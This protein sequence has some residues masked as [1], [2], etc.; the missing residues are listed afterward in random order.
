MPVVVTGAGSALGHAVVTA[1][2]Q[3][4]VEVRVTVRAREER[5]WFAQRRVPAAV[6]DLSDPLRT[7]AV[8]EGAFTVVHLDSPAATWEWLLDAAEE[9]SVRRVLVVAPDPAVP[10]APA[11]LEVVR[12]RGDPDTADPQVVAAVV[13]ADARR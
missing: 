9:T 8:L 12:L 5:E 3:D 4:G 6:S 7:G 11:H 2:L 10:D 13:A 1:L